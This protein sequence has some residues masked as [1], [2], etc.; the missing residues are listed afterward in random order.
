MAGL[1]AQASD[2]KWFDDPAIANDDEL[3]RVVKTDHQIVP[4]GDGTFGVSAQLWTSQG[5]GCSVE[6]MSLVAAANSDPD[7]RVTANVGHGASG[8]EVA[9]HPSG[10]DRGLSIAAPVVRSRL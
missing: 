10:E 8:V 7:E 5:A 1:T 9:E 4:L 3:I 2:G 6:L